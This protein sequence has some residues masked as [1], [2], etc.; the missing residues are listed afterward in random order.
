M[1]HAKEEL[2][3]LRELFTEKTAEQIR[4]QT[5]LDDAKKR[6]EEATKAI[7]DEGFTPKTLPA[8]ITKMKAELDDALVEIRTQLEGGDGDEFDFE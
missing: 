4:A 8:A 2:K 5:R 3:T 7:K 6:R 1:A